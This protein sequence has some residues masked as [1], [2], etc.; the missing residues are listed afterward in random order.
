MCSHVFTDKEI[1][2]REY[3]K[4]YTAPAGSEH[5]FTINGITKSQRSVPTEYVEQAID[6]ELSKVYVSPTLYEIL[7]KRLYTL[8]LEKRADLDKQIKDTRKDIDKLDDK[9]RA[10]EERITQEI[11]TLTDERREDLE[12]T[13]EQ[14]REKIEELETKIKVIRGEL[15]EEFEKAWQILYTLF[16]AKNI[17]SES[18]K[19]S[20]EPKR[21]LLLSM[22]SNIIFLDGNIIMNWKSPFDMLATGKLTKQKSQVDPEI[23]D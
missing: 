4:F 14:N 2:K 10:T 12:F 6:A 15:E 11:D 17:F 13:I 18:E 19:E 8:W 21:N 22:V 23:F 1:H 5:S 3:R 20:F 16:E 9:R 7:R